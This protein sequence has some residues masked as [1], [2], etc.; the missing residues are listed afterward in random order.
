MYSILEKERERER[1][2]QACMKSDWG[3][4]GEREREKVNDAPDGKT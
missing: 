3:L 2:T 1:E 4:F